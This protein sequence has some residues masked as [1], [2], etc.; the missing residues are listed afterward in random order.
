[1]ATRNL[2]R[3][4]DLT[5]LQLFLAV[6]EEGTLTR[7]AERE[8]IA[9]SAASKRLL[10]LEQA[11]GAVLF[12]RKARGMALTPAGE[13]LLH[14]AR[15]VLRDVENIGIE[16]AEHA[17]GVR[18]YVRMMANLSAIVEFLPED[19]RAFSSMHEQIKIDLEERP[20]GGIVEGVADSLVDLG[21]CSGDADT[22][23]L[24]TAHYRH[25]R[26]ALVVP[27]DHLLAGRASIAFAQTLDFD[28]IGLHSASSINMRTHLAARQAGRALRLRIHVPGFDAVCRMVQAG[29]GVGVLPMQ[30]FEAMGRQLGLAAIALDDEWAARSLVIVVRDSDALSPVSRLL[31]DHLRTVE[32]RV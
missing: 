27:G 14:H 24:E 16:L 28:H 7:A 13:T 20:S 1:M 5:T 2:L 11:V 26:L 22:R 15:R 3:R 18:G 4:L 21:I 19:L 25:D 12:E 23:G 6:F 29:M 31:F 30:V 17:S 9:V 8:A 32:A 10:E